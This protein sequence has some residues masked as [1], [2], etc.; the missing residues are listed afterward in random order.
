MP[1]TRKVDS[2]VRARSHRTYLSRSGVNRPTWLGSSEDS[3]SVPRRNLEAVA[4]AVR[5]S[6]GAPQIWGEVFGDKFRLLIV[7]RVGEG[8]GEVGC[9]ESGFEEEG[10]VSFV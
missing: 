9:E 3:Q 8:V 4:L 5:V 6:S 1:V 2:T 7:P 10:V